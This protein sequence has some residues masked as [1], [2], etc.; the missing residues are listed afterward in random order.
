MVMEM[1]RFQILRRDS[2][3]SFK[4][5][6]KQGPAF[7]LLETWDFCLSLVEDEVAKRAEQRG[8]FDAM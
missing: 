2:A 8:W 6:V 7:F 4:N 5:M 1:T 3:G